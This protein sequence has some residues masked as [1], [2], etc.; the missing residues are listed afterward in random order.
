LKAATK[1]PTNI[2]KMLPG[3]RTEPPIISTWKCSRCLLHLYFYCYMLR[4]SFLSTPRDTDRAWRFHAG[5]EIRQHNVTTT[6]SDKPLRHVQDAV[7]VNDFIFRQ[8]I[9]SMVV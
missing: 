6:T 3:P 7:S 1:A 9:L 4:L 8:K 5:T 2:R